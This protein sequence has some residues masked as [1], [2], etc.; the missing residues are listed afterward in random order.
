MINEEEAVKKGFQILES[1]SNLLHSKEAKL[2]L[3]KSIIPSLVNSDDSLDTEYLKNLLGLGNLTYEK[4]SYGLNF[5]GKGLA[6]I[7]AS[8]ST[9]KELRLDTNASKNLDKTDNLIIRGDNLDAI[10]I[11]R[12][13][14]DGK[15]KVIY[16]D[17]PYNTDNARFI[18][19]D[20]FKDSEAELIKKYELTEEQVKFFDC[21]FGTLN[22]SSWLFNM[23]SRLL[24]ARDLLSDDG[25]IFLSIDDHEQANLKLLCDEIFGE[26]NLISNMVWRKKYGG[27]KGANNVVD[28]HEY[29]LCYAKVLNGYSLLGIPRTAK[30]KEVFKEEDKHLKERGRYYIRPLKSGLAKRET[31]IYPIECPDGTSIETQWICG[32]DEFNRLLEEDRIV[33][34]KRKKDGSYNVYKKFYQFDRGELIIPDSLIYDLAYNQNGKE[35]V[36]KIFGIKEGR[37]VPFDNPKPLELIQHFI[38]IVTS[39]DKSGIV[40]DF[41]AGSGTTAHAVMDLNKNDGGKR[42]FILV[43]LDQ[44]IDPKKSDAAESAYKYCQD[45]KLAPVISSMTIERV[46]RS[47]EMIEATNGMLD[48]DFDSGYKVFALTDKPKI[49]ESGSAGIGL[50]INR[51]TE[52]DTLYNMMAASGEHLLTEPIETLEE[53]L[54]YKVGD[55][56]FVL[57]QC[58]TNLEEL[59]GHRIYVDGYS[60]IRLADWMNM[61]QADKELV[62]IIY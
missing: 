10:K 36:K 39:K 54:L 43:E 21:M 7:K 55:A 20:S 15:V 2:E 27:G 24:L 19:D 41:F 51:Q 42:K 53:K 28:L 26:D 47:S 56:Y 62:Q 57:G 1:K 31:L 50:N 60:E 12:Q 59:A 17:P 23:Y 3:I 38:K 35:E 61:T 37:E 11:L 9:S 45:N 14:Y 5:P 29:V 18:Y 44:K 49:V 22:H 32:K 58:K 13:N 52:L 48:E 33:F 4:Q 6:R 8:V 30:Q 34:V 25:V 40:L 16:I 46:R